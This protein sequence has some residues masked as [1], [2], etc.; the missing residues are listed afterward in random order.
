MPLTDSMIKIIKTVENNG[1]EYVFP[2]PTS[3]KRM[4]SENTLNM[5]LKRMGYKDVMT[6][7]GFRHTASTLL[8]ENMHLHGIPS[9]VIE[10]QLAHVEKNAI[11]ST[12]NKALYM[13]QRTKLMQWWSD[14]LDSMKI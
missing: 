4:M 6:S 3:R 5:A 1:S 13:D 12:Y 11:K 7:H 14:Y 2:A 9:E 10:I 8:H